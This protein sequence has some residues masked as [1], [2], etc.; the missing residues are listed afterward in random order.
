MCFLF[1]NIS[2]I[3]NAYLVE[4]HV[5]SVAAILMSEQQYWEGH[6]KGRQFGFDNLVVHPYGLS[7]NKELPE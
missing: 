3:I 2:I 4:G 7:S 6:H 5:E 1:A